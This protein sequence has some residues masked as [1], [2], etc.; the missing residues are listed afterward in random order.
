MSLKD[1][2]EDLQGNG[3][4]YIKTYPPGPNSLEKI[5][6]A[7]KYITSYWT[8][9]KKDHGAGWDL[10]LTVKRAANSLI[11]DVDGNIYIDL[12]SG[13][14]TANFGYN[15]PEIWIRAQ[16]IM[17]EYGVLGIFPSNDYNLP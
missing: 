17:N 6:E 9:K 7:K 16:E 13:I 4:P 10:P 11:E 1:W 15:N 5:Q 3:V 12:N 2:S 14:S 8:G